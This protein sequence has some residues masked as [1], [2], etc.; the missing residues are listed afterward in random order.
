MWTTAQQGP[1]RARWRRAD[2]GSRRRFESVARAS[3][4]L[5]RASENWA[6]TVSMTGSFGETLECT[7][8]TCV[9]EGLGL[10]EF[11]AAGGRRRRYDRQTLAVGADFQG[12][13]VVN[14]KQ[15][16]DRPVDHQGHA[17]A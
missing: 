17:V 15:V 1:I 2:R 5:R 8:V 13:L 10:L 7:P 3:R 4:A 11:L 14:L 12:R 9:G 16:Q 6:R